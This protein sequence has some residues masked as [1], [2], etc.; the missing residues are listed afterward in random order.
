M[1]RRLLQSIGPVISVCLFVLA[2]V[3]IHH[4][5]RG[6]RY[7]DIVYQMQ[8]IGYRD[9]A[10]AVVL[11]ILNYLVLTANDALA[12]RYARHPLPYRQLAFASFIGYA[13]S[14]S[15]TVV[16]G[17][18]A[19]YRIYTALGLS[20]SEIAEVVVYCGL[21]VWLGFFLVAGTSFL[22][23]PQYVPLPQ[24]LHLP[25]QSV[26]IAGIGCLVL[27]GVYMLAVMLR[28]RPI[29]LP[30]WQLRVPSPALSIGQIAVTSTDWLLAA[31]VLY[32][33]LP[34]PM[35]ATYPKFIGIFMLGQGLGM[36]SHV[37]GGLGVFE[38]VLLFA[39]SG[40]GDAA[41]LTAALVLYRL[42]YYIGPL[43]LGALLLAIHEVLLR[44]TL[45]R[46]IGI[47]VGRWGS[48]V[49]PQVF[50]LAV[51]VAGSI[52]LFSGA[53]PPVRGRAEIL[54]DLLPLPAIE[55]SH[56][57]GS[58]TGAMLLIL[59][60]G[61]Q[62]RLDGAYHLTILMLLAGMGFSL[63]KGLDYE[64]AIILAVMLAALLPCRSQFYR[65]ASLTAQRFSPGW[66]TLIVIVLLCS[67]WLGLFAYKHVDYS[68]ELWWKFTFRDG[69]PR[70]LR[71]TAGAVALIL[72]YAVARLLVPARPQ[73][74]PR[75][76]D[77]LAKVHEI[78]RSSPRT[79]ANLA[80]LGDKQFL[81]SDSQDAFLMYGVENRSWVAMG[82][83]VGPQEQWEDLTWKF[84][85]LCDRYHGQP[86]FYQ[87][88]GQTL[89]LYTNLGMTFLKLGE[90]ARVP[91]ASFSLEG[92][93][94]RGLRHSHNKLSG[95]GY[96]FRIVPTE[97]VPG[98]LDSLK[99]V[100]DAWLQAKNTREKGFSLG[101]FDPAYLARCP[102]AVV[103]N[104]EGIA[105]FANLW[106]GSGKQ[107]LSIDL[108]R[109]LPSCPEGLMD[110]L[111]IEL[112][113]WGRQEGY[114]W[115][116]LGMAP[117]S[118][119]EN[120]AL[121]PL[122]SKTGNLIFRLGEHFYNFQGLRQ[123]KEKFDPEWHA[124]FLACRG[125]MALP[126]ILTNVASLISGGLRGIVKK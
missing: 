85:E 54:R 63:L 47:H 92:A 95:S 98:L 40:G 89:D 100:S 25:V 56:F 11:T 97:Q 37:P 81:L 38:T 93:S 120:R 112:M 23:D 55:L 71:G 20:A 64:E 102:V 31:G 57:L 75:N 79:Y 36:I 53:L 61:L 111:L 14:N 82:D 1:N 124:K 114:Q 123:Y 80:L 60:R 86:A 65:K 29:A 117:L 12:L 15:A 110:Y 70:F 34:D 99:R 104:A 87:I 49:A 126:R 118:G 122:W 78:V 17:S 46:R 83:P 39:L 74:A 108:M 90:E 69:A 6:Y 41:A 42:I 4:E 66:V 84:I 7:R 101:F 59:A 2:I 77:T 91:L 72:L 125:G 30:G 3:L 109:H 113:Q 10:T 21:T 26:G 22:L 96:T 8:Q 119:L 73:P 52:L 106:Q 18:A 67:A 24:K 116:N 32:V 76:E 5:L 103:D 33:L 62:R 68:H 9:I 121:A 48:A 44:M 16:G 13:F 51:F 19:R 94:R 35:Q 28:R 115:F 43:L 45:V 88:D 50:A 58:L 27:V 105:A 107:E